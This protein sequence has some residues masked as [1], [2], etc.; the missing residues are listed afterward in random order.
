MTVRT[1]RG[2]TAE[3]RRAVEALFEQ[4]LERRWHPG[5]QLA[6]YRDGALVLDLAGGEA[7]RGRRV[8]CMVPVRARPALMPSA[9]RRACPTRWTG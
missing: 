7:E 5:A 2:L 1:V 8:R 6:V 3:G 4:Q 9:V